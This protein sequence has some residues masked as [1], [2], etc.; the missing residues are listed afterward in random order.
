MCEGLHVKRMRVSLSV[1]LLDVLRYRNMLD[2]ALELLIRFYHRQ[3]C[4]VFCVDAMFYPLLP[5]I[6]ANRCW[7]C[8]TDGFIFHSCQLTFHRSVSSCTSF[9]FKK[10]KKQKKKNKKKTAVWN[11]NPPPRPVRL[12]SERHAQL[13]R[14]GSRV[15]E[16]NFLKL[17]AK[18]FSY[19]EMSLFL[20]NKT[21]LALPQTPA[22]CLWNKSSSVIS[23]WHFSS[24][25]FRQSGHLFSSRP[26]CQFSFDLCM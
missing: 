3:Y 22:I 14:T 5:M 2:R 6:I 8:L 13:K 11:I 4:K 26:Y 18:R 25:I 16:F 1:C 10:K 23:F 20:T 24:L 12:L 7:T 15:A 9:F 19:W 17:S 21:S